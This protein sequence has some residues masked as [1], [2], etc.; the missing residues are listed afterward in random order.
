MQRQPDKEVFTRSAWYYYA[1]PIVLIFVFSS[2]LVFA[3]SNSVHASAARP[4][5]NNGLAQTPLMGWSSW[6]TIR[7]NPSESAIKAQAQAMANT[8]KSYGYSYINLDD[9]WYLN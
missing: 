5:E 2:V 6:S 7:T 8:L 9:Y 3:G 4:Q 1:I